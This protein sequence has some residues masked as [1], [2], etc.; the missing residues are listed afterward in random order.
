MLV[1]R[2]GRGEAGYDRGSFEALLTTA[3]AGAGEMRPPQLTA[4]KPGEASGVLLGGTLTQL[5]ASLATPYAFSPPEGFVLF[6]DEVG[7]RPYRIDRMFTQLRLS[8]ILAR[9]SAI[10]FGE[11]PRCDD[12]AGEPTARA[13]VEDLVRDFSGPVLAGFPSGHTTGPAWTLPFGINVRVSA[14]VRPALV[15][16]EP[17]V[18]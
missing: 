10:V 11:L 2:L 8:G 6:L 3:S 5:V 15:I 9:A 16:E 14:G 7:E 18:E 12:P 17:A 1:G 13:V 4:V